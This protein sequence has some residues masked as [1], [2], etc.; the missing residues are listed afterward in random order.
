[1][2]LESAKENLNLFRKKYPDKEIIEISALKHEGL[3][4]LLEYL[5]QILD[6]IQEEAIYQDEE[7]ESTIVYRFKNEKPYT[8]TKEDGIWVIRGK[9]IEKLFA[10]TRFDQEEA[11]LRF[12]RKLRGM[13]IEE[14]LERLGAKRNDEIQINDYI[15]EFK[16]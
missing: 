7:Y 9:E 2:D 10:M 6:T 13:G 4:R 14:E 5:K 16:D 3:E 15:F 8:I 12:A 11:V 1:M